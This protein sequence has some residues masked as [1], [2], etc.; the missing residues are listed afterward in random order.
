MLANITIC[1]DRCIGVDY[2][3]KTREEVNRTKFLG[4]LKVEDT[5]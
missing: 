1:I 4:L 5:H 2:D 3:N